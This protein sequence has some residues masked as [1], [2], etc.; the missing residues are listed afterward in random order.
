MSVVEYVVREDS[1][2]LK[3]KLITPMCDEDMKHFPNLLS[4]RMVDVDEYWDNLY[5]EI[6]GLFIDGG[7]DVV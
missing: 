7:N 1:V 5:G 3:L 2:G 4:K 6:K